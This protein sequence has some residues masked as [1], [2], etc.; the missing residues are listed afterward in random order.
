MLKLYN[1]LSCAKEI[2]KPVKENKVNMYVC[3]ITP[4]D[5]VHLGHARCYVV[6][7]V[8]RRYLIHCGYKVKYIQN[9]TDIDDKI[10]NKSLELR[11]ES[12]ELA[13]RYIDDYFVQMR[14]LN[15]LD[16]NSYPRVTQKIPQIVGLIKKIIANGYAYEIDGD[17]YFSVRKSADYGKLSKR[18]IE[19]LKAG[20]RVEVGEQKKDP[21]DFALWKKSKEGEP[22]WDSPWGKGR[23]GWHIE[24]SVMSLDEFGFDTFDIHGGGQDLIFPH[25]ENEIAQS[26]AALGREFVKYWLHN[27]FVTINNEKMSKSL[28]NFFALEDIFKKYEPMVVRYFLISQHYRSP[29]DF[30][31]HKLEQSKH[32]IERIKN[33]IFDAHILVQ[34]VSEVSNTIVGGTEELIKSIKDKFNKAMSD[35][36]NTAEALAAIHSASNHLLILNRDKPQGLNK[37]T[38]LFVIETLTEL[39]N[40]LG[41]DL[42]TSETIP[43]DVIKLADERQIARKSKDWRRSDEIRE[44]IKTLGFEIEDTKFGPRI[45]K[46]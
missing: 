18:N 44:K 17:V 32:A 31:D 46:I 6:F 21:L 42:S 27:G 8:I 23:P 38:L 28:G 35:D 1:T 5:R 36:F 26:E 14:K 37:K 2:F 13:N 20:A 4:Y 34:Q 9:F 45:K 24:C 33:A 41:I 25:H 15:V 30:S 7:D 12:L 11:V 3:G 39:F 43:P 40:I 29:I 22:S 16:A 19:E 10:I